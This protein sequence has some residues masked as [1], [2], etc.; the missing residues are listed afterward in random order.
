LGGPAYVLVPH[1]LVAG[2]R[3]GGALP[4]RP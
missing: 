2:A 1:L 4:C 3:C